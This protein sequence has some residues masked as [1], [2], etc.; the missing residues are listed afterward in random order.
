MKKQ[1][2]DF[3]KKHGGSASSLAIVRSVLHMNAASLPAAEAVLRSILA[4]D[5]LFISDGMGTWHL[6]AVAVPQEQAGNTLSFLCVQ[7]DADHRMLS[8]ARRISVAWVRLSGT[9]QTGEAVHVFDLEQNFTSAGNAVIALLRDLPAETVIASWRP[10]RFRQL[11]RRLGLAQELARFWEADLGI[12][13]QNSLDLPVRP[14]LEKACRILG[15]EIHSDADPLTMVRSS[16]D[17]LAVIL[18]KAAQ[19]QP[20]TL[21]SIIALAGRRQ[22]MVS[23]ERYQFKSTDVKNLPDRPGVYLMRD[24]RKK[25]IYVGK[26]KNLRVRVQSYFKRREQTDP[27]LHALLERIVTLDWKEL[28]T[29]LDALIEEARLIARHKPEINIMVHVH[30]SA[31][32]RTSLILILPA[33]DGEKAIVWLVR[34]DGF[35]RIV[36]P[37]RR[38][39][40]KKLLQ[41][42]RRY[43]FSDS[44]ALKEAA[45]NDALELILRYCRQHRDRLTLISPADFPDAEQCHS[46][47]ITMLEDFSALAEKQIIRA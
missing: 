14:A 35:A 40:R 19:E 24:S 41:E 34:Q 44:D 39:P 4:D 45:S 6:N 5:P 33:A 15:L 32:E 31:L 37:R 22:T 42:I 17:V 25:V 3:L 9:E 21:E 43:Y 20:L 10:A 23:F 13:V 8:Q 30:E 46:A 47:L 1:I 7:V 16:A 2:H 11:V 26:A 28:D 36:C 12:L 27:K 18:Q 38:L 29:E